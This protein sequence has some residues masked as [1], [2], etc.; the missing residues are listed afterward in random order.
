MRVNAPRATVDE[1]PNIQPE[2][3]RR[4]VLAVMLVNRLHECECARSQSRCFRLLLSGLAYL[5]GRWGRINRFRQL[6]RA[7]SEYQAVRLR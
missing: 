1:K 3:S 2:I 6:R 7:H 4:V 5:A